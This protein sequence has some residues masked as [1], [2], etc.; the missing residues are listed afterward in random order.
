MRPSLTAASIGAALVLLAGCQ[1]HRAV[2][3]AS[4]SSAVTRISPDSA[5]AA[6]PR[7]QVGLMVD[8]PEGRHYRFDLDTRSRATRRGTFLLPDTNGVSARIYDAEPGALLVE[9]FDP[10][11][12]VPSC[13]P[14]LLGCGVPHPGPSEVD[15]LHADGSKIAFPA[16]KNEC[17]ATIIAHR[18]TP[19]LLT[20]TNVTHGSHSVTAIQLLTPT[21]QA[22]VVMEVIRLEACFYSMAVS[23]DAKKVAIPTANPDDGKRGEVITANLDGSRNQHSVHFAT[24]A[25]TPV[26]VAW[27]PDGTQLA[28]ITREKHIVGD[29]DVGIYRIGVGSPNGGG[30]HYFSTNIDE[31]TLAWLTPHQLLVGR[32]G[33]YVVIDPA[34]ASQRVPS[35]LQGFVV[36]PVRTP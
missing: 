28:M 1:H 4:S 14:L 27:S 29:T 35:G 6:A 20:A 34:T 17:S 2:A 19:T 24:G 3:T 10:P 5:M 15:L 32:S 18:A 22:K 26:R 25:A 7:D 33:S 11:A 30:V 12:S 21:G 36:T 16:A 8:S 23:P 9:H 13:P 31:Q